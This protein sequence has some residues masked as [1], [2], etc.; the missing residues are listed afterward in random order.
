MQHNLTQTYRPKQLRELVGQDHIT[1]VI[2]ADLVERKPAGFYICYGQSGAGKT[3]LARMAATYLNCTAFKNVPCNKCINCVKIRNGTSSLVREI[4][5]ADTTGVDA[6]RELIQSLRYVIGKD[7]FRIVIMDECH[8]LTKNAWDV[9]LKPLED[10]IRN[11]VFFFCTT[12][13]IKVPKT[14]RSRAVNNGYNF[15]PV[16]DKQTFRVLKGISKMENI[17]A[18]DDQLERIAMDSE[19]SVRNAVNTLAQFYNAGAV[20]SDVIR[21]DYGGVDPA[22]SIKLFTLLHANRFKDAYWIVSAW[23]KEGLLPVTIHSML[24]EHVTNLLTNFALK[25][26]GWEPVEMRKMDAQRKQYGEIML[27]AML[28]NLVQSQ[29]Y[30]THVSFGHSVQNNLIL[31]RLHQCIQAEIAK[32]KSVKMSAH[33]RGVASHETLNDV[34]E[35][36]FPS[37]GAL[38]TVAAALS[39]SLNKYDP[40][41]HVGI[42]FASR[43][44]V[45]VLDVIQPTK[46]CILVADVPALI[47]EIKKNSTEKISLDNN[48]FIHKVKS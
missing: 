4:N 39:G 6:S 44:P 10:G 32:V 3:T 35:D 5:A 14:A 47:A 1:S 24:I 48:K 26:R 15:K 7:K 31:G 28:E 11:T 37:R 23:G 18:T 46:N 43:Q 16:S 41:K 42:I 36:S 9:W 38:E 22:D 12:E 20:D 17:D 29:I 21:Q 45:F 8:R 33:T 25:Y 40:E 2:E 27:G 13:I 19:G 30:L 34:I